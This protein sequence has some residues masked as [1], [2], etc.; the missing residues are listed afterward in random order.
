MG[1]KLQKQAKS[2]GL[3]NLPKYTF[4]CQPKGIKTKFST[5]KPK[6]IYPIVDWLRSFDQ[7]VQD[8][9]TGSARQV[10]SFILAPQAGVYIESTSKIA[11][12]NARSASNY[13]S[14]VDIYTENADIVKEVV[15]ILYYQWE[16][17]MVNHVNFEKIEKKFKVKR[18]DIINAFNSF[19]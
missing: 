3:T 6:F 18:D 17:G 13:V 15:K 4:Y 7:S 12:F 14:Q 1:R 5:T 19:L 10:W 11:G 8:D 2:I 16:D 9:D